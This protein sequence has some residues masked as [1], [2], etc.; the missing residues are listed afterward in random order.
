MLLYVAGGLVGVIALGAAALQFAVRTNGPAVLNTLD[1]AVGG[2]QG[3][4]VVARASTGDHPE[5][6]VIVWGRTDEE[7]R[8]EALPVAVF[9]HGGSWRDGDPDDYGFVGRA[10]VPQGF[11]T[12]LGGYR[13]GKAGIYPAMLEDAAAV[14]AWTRDN[15]ARY[16][17]DPDRIVLIGHSAGAYNT[18]T[19]VLDPRWLDRA[20]VSMDAIKGV[21][22]LAGPYDFAPF[23]SESTI[24]AFGHVDPPEPTQPIAYFDDAA[25][26]NLPQMLLVHGEQDDTVKIRNSRALAAKLETAGSSPITLYYP[27]MDHSDPLIA[28]AAPVRARSRAFEFISGFARAVTNGS[29]ASVP[30]QAELR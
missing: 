28:F 10:M 8:G 22:G 20:G 2:T 3:A 5:Q 23:D 19:S 13:L 17:G 14:I 15:I 11:V 16:G 29:D 7:A 27:D 25:Q 12:V 9:V 4:E 30:V 26:R 21:I 18:V 6:K 1:R 24:A